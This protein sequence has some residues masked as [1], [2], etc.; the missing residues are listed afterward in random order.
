MHAASSE[1]LKR[2]RDLGA[3]SGAVK[4]SQPLQHSSRF[5]PHA[6]GHLYRTR[7]PHRGPLSS[8]A[9]KEC[10]D[11]HRAA[12][13]S[14]IRRHDEPSDRVPA[15]L[16]LRAPELFRAALQL[17][18]RRQEPGRLRPRHRRTLGR[19][20]RAR[21][22]AVGQPGSA[23]LLDRGLLVRR[24]DRHAAP[25]APAGDR[26]LYLDRAAGQPLRLLLPR[27]LPVLRA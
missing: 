17:P 7:R 18:R 20:G 19:R 22:G 25:D 15:L 21:L 8:G 26:G 2:Y 4:R 1:N 27:P 3:P 9:A 10:A 5:K 24:L 23:Q 12:P 13:A 6:R 14:A 16:R 11:R